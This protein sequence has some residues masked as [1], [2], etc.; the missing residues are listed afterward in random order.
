MI[1]FVTCYPEKQN[2]F[3]YEIKKK[4]KLFKVC[5]NTTS[6]ID[7]FPINPLTNMGTWKKIK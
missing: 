3:K 4:K 6:S 1:A 5:P 7:H 2:S